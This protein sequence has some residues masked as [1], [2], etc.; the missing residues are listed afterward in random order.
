MVPRHELVYSGLQMAGGEG[1]Q[2]EG[3]VGEELDTVQLAC[4]DQ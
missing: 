4:A 1:L 2:Q 3:H